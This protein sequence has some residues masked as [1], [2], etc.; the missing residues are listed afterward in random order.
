MG[1]KLIILELIQNGLDSNRHLV[2]L[3]GTM[4]AY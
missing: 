3:E 4:D 1:K 2:Y